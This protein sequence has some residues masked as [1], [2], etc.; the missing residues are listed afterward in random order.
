VAYSCSSICGGGRLAY[1]HKVLKQII[2]KI[3]VARYKFQ[4][5]YSP[6]SWWYGVKSCPTDH[7]LICIKI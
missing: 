7:I 5:M 6:C 1:R 4:N 3:T 2:V